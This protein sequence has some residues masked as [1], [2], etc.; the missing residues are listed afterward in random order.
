MAGKLW[1]ASG[2][3][4]VSEAA[5]GKAIKAAQPHREGSYGLVTGVAEILRLWKS[6]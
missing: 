4:P 6:N 2:R 1:D 3:H 5:Y